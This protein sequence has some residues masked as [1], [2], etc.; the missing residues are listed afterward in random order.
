MAETDDNVEGPRNHFA[1]EVI[2]EPI[3][4]YHPTWIQAAHEDPLRLALEK[5]RQIADLDAIES[6]LQQ[7]RNRQRVALIVESHHEFIDVVRARIVEQRC[8]RMRVYELFTWYC[9]G[10][11]RLAPHTRRGEIRADLI[12]DAIHESVDA[13]L[14]PPSTSTLRWKNSSTRRKK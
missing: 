5:A 9:H 14:P 13:R 8:D 6:A 3:A 1:H 2:A 4:E 10:F 7:L 11:T 12:D